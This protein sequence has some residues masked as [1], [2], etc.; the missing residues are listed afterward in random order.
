VFK[1]LM[2]EGSRVLGLGYRI[3]EENMPIE[4]VHSMVCGVL[5]VD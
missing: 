3:V 1:G 5:I 2:R 4:K